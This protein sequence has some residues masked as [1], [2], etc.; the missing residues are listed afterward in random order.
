MYLNGFLG[1]LYLPFSLFVFK[2]FYFFYIVFLSFFFF[3]L[4]FFSTFISIEKRDRQYFK[5]DTRGVGWRP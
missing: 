2:L 5:P 1:F 3:A 4:N